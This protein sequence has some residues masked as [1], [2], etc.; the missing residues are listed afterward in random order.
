VFEN[1]GP[2]EQVKAAKN[3]LKNAIKMFFFAKFLTRFLKKEVLALLVCF[4]KKK[5]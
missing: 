3:F 4:C 1:L 2:Q 5:F